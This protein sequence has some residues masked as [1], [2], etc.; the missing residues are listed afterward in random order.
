MLGID[1]QNPE[2]AA[3][4]VLSRCPSQVRVEQE[5]VRAEQE[6]G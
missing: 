2:V 6:Q 3:F 4:V 5:Q 1:E